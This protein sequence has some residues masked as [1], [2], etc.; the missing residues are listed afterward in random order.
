M[1]TLELRERLYVRKSLHACSR[2]PIGQ[3]RV[4]VC[5]FVLIWESPLG[6]YRLRALRVAQGLFAEFDQSLDCRHSVS[7]LLLTVYRE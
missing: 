1:G 5:D 6:L 2:V 7:L 4:S 3:S